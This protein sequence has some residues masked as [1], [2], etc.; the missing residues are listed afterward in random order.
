MRLFLTV[1]LLSLFHLS[2]GQ[3]Y[4]Q[5]EVNYKINVKLDDEK[6]ILRGQEEF[7]YVNNSPNTLDKIYIHLW[8]NAYKNGETALAKQLYAGGETDL[9][10]GSVCVSIGFISFFFDNFSTFLTSVFISLFAAFKTLL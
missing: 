3:S 5:Q 4:W 6:H 10:F 2:F 1:L 9:K 7:E 8:A